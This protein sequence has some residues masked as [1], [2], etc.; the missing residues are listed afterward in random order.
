MLY[1]WISLLLP[2]QGQWSEEDKFLLIVGLTLGMKKLKQD[3]LLPVS[4]N[5]PTEVKSVEGPEGNIAEDT[6]ETESE[7]DGENIMTTTASTELS[8]ERMVIQMA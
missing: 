6:Q 3:K 5:A 8:A 7:S 2:K 4:T 1:L